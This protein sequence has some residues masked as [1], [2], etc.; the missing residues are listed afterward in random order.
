MKSWSQMPGTA[1]VKGPHRR[2]RTRDLVVRRDFVAV[3]AASAADLALDPWRLPVGI[4][5]AGELPR[6]AHR[7]S[8]GPPSACT[9]HCYSS[10]LLR[11]VPESGA[12][13]HSIGWRSRSA[14][15]RVV[16]SPRSHPLPVSAG[17]VAVPPWPRMPRRPIE[18]LQELPVP[19]CSRHPQCAEESSLRLRLPRRFPFP[20][21]PVRGRCGCG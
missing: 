12:G 9:R 20:N 19:P 10:H 4:A 1:S 11:K 13:F 3:R 18:E 5:V 15:T 17:E 6:L 2:P 21:W 16:P 8:L 7:A 14:M